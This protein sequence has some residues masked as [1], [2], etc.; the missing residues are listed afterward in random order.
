MYLLAGISTFLVI[1]AL[2]LSGI[3]GA[4]FFLRRGDHYGPLNDLFFALSLFLLILPVIAVNDLANEQVGMWFDAV[5]WVAVVGMVVAGVG[6]LLLVAGAISLQTSFKS[7]SISIAPLLAWMVSLA[8]ISIREEVP[9]ALVGWTMTLSIV[10]M[11]PTAL[12]P[13]FRVR[14]SLRLWAGAILGFA[15]VAWLLALGV[16]LVDRA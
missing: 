6:Q 12:L 2:L 16:D 15:L 9:D 10:L 11:V 7:G 14:M 1:P 8:V 5:T 3:F 13:A 4:L